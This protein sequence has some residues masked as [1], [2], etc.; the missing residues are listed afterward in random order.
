[1]FGNYRIE[2]WSFPI[3]ATGGTAS[4]RF[5]VMVDGNGNTIKELHGGAAGPNGT[6]KTTALSGTLFTMEGTPGKTDP[7]GHLLPYD[8]NPIASVG[9]EAPNSRFEYTV[10]EGSQAAMQQAWNAALQAGDAINQKELLYLPTPTGALD[11]GNSNGSLSVFVKAA[12][13]LT[14]RNDASY[15][16][17]PGSVA[18]PLTAAEIDAA[19]IAA[20]QPPRTG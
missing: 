15:Y 9:P 6:F 14:Y 3:A 1:M 11:D 13:D 7:Q 16:G 17:T 12:S 2:V 8:E 19:R 4:H 5:L 20:G 18:E 10:N